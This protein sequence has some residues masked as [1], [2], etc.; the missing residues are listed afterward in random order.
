MKE[1][2]IGEAIA[3]AA[4]TFDTRRM[5]MGEPGLPAEFAWRGETIRIATVRREW[6]DTGP[7]DH[8]SDERYLRRHWYEIE[9]DAGRVL[10]LY[11]ERNP[12]DRKT[13]AR[14]RLFSMEERDERNA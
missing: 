5:A 6:R 7:C 13:M 14:W 11:F 10:K 3:P 2:F 8:G 12:R 9:D 1:Q 4:A